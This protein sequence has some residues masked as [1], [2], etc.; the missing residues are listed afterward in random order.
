MAV[1]IAADAK[2][3]KASDIAQYWARLSQA[4]GRNGLKSDFIDLRA[5]RPGQKSVR[6]E[7]D[8]VVTNSRDVGNVSPEYG[9]IGVQFGAEAAKRNRTFYIACSEWAAYRCQRDAGVRA[10]RIIFGPVDLDGVFPVERQMVRSAKRPIV[11]HRGQAQITEEVAAELGEA[12]DVRRLT[13]PP[14]RVPDAMRSSDMWL[15]LSAD[16]G[17]SADVQAAQATNLVVV[18]TNV[19]VLWPYGIGEMDGTGAWLNEECGA[20]VFGVQHRDDPKHIAGC[21]RTAWER[22][23]MLYPRAH[24]LR[25]Y[26]LDTFGQKWLDALVLAADRFKLK[27]PPVPKPKPVPLS[28]IVEAKPTRVHARPCGEG[29]GNYGR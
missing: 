25:W 19:G 6:P 22:R 4:L 14:H 15:S 11:I 17:L 29:V 10:D 5:V 12:F 8:I 13:C 2:L 16:D 24:A 3:D 27:A 23:D 9:V 26:G 21:V 20:A 28:P 1:K 18:G 7:Y